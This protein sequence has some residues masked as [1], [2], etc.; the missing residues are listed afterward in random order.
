MYKGVVESFLVIALAGLG[1]AD[2]W[3]LSD[4]VRAGG[5][6]RDVIGPDRYLAFISAGLLV[7]GVGYLVATW[8]GMN[9]ARGDRK[10]EEG[11]QVTQVSL[12]FIVVI[13][14]VLALPLLGYM[15]ATLFFFPVAFFIFGVK[16]WLKSIIVGLLTA[17]L[18]YA[19]FA[20]LAEVPLPRGLWE[21]AL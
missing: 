1:L 2:A 18:F 8:K 15:L 7:C 5:T 10:E 14:Y 11:S 17:V 13:I 4:A 16:P 3:R 6:F 12:V 9:Q 21:L 20:Y 19:I